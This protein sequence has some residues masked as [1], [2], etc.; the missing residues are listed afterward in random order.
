[1][2]Q[3]VQSR[4]ATQ[5]AIDGAIVVRLRPGANGEIR[6]A[7][8]DARFEEN[9]NRER[10]LRR[11][12][13]TQPGEWT[14]ARLMLERLERDGEINFHEFSRQEREIHDEFGRVSV[15]YMPAVGRFLS[16]VE[17]TPVEAAA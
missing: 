14:I 13:E 5:E 15:D 11:A 7:L 9:K 3:S 17:L 16:Y 12:P 1:M 2:T 8:S 6:V 4:L 10:M